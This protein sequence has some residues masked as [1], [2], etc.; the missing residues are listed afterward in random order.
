MRPIG[1]YFGREPLRA[2][3]VACRPGL[4]RFESARS[5]FRALLAAGRPPCVHLPWF[6]CPAMVAQITGLGI[7]ACEY[8]IARDGSPAP[9]VALRDGEWIV[10]VDFFGL[11]SCQVL[12]ALERWPAA[13]VVVDQA[14]AWH[15]PPRV[16]LATLYSPRKFAGLPDG[17][18]M[19][20]S[21]LE[22]ASTA[23][24]EDASWQRL[25]ALDLRDAGQLAEGLAA[26][27]LG[28]AS[29]DRGAARAMSRVSASQ[30]DRIDFHVPRERRLRN[31]ARLQLQLGEWD[32]L[33]WHPGPEDVPLCYPLLHADADRLRARLVEAG[34]YCARYWPGLEVA[35]APGWE[36]MLADQ[37]LCLPVDQRYDDADMDRV[38]ETVVAA[39]DRA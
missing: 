15:A 13:Q 35:S 16:A 8:G 29:L 28:E 21:R 24:D 18:L 37:L 27:R 39:L 6:L 36:R 5:A 3:P 14:Q 25:R 38:A 33:G 9:D 32:S 4:L 31:H 26:F 17:G 19:A 34:I 22:V 30:L 20:C 2:D 12:S 7:E 10:L 23:A 11:R 1:G